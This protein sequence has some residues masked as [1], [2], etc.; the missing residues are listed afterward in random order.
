MKC[1]EQNQE[2]KKGITDVD[3]LESRKKYNLHI[4]LL[5][6]CIG[7]CPKYHHEIPTL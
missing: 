3:D 7:V 6:T 2:E 4:Y 1:E 5:T